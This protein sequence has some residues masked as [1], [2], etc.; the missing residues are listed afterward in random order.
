MWDRREAAGG[1]RAGAGARLLGRA[2]PVLGI[3]VPI[4]TAHRDTLPGHAG[5]PALPEV[6]QGLGPWGW[7]DG[8]RPEAGAN[9]SVTSNSSADLSPQIPHL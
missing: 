4:S 1:R 9:I 2:H 8:V 5:Q 3:R 6:R 7:G